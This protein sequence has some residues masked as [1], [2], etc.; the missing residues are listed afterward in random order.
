M[1]ASVIEKALL[2]IEFG[3]LGC[4]LGVV[5]A[6]LGQLLVNRNGFNGKAVLRVLVADFLEVI[7]GLIVVADA[8]VKVPDGVQHRQVLGIFLDDLFVFGNR[9]GQLALLDKL[10]RLRQDL[11]FVEPK[12]ECH[13]KSVNLRAA[14]PSAVGNCKR[15][16]LGLKY[17]RKT[18]KPKPHGVI[19]STCR[20]FT[21]KVRPRSVQFGKILELAPIH[22]PELQNSSVLPILG[23]ASE[24]PDH[25]F[26]KILIVRR[27]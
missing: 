16:Q 8:R 22:P 9:V 14:F 26:Q 18:A 1:H 2:A 7:R 15:V 4:I 5:R 27:A 13:K 23:P 19:V 17:H 11:Y 25:Q 21:L 20:L 10:L 6:D 12:P 3:Q 24:L